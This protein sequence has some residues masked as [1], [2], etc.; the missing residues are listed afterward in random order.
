MLT[1][2]LFAVANFVS[3]NKNIIVPQYTRSVPSCV[4]SKYSS[5]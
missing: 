4:S 3:E 1:R 2:D 5:A